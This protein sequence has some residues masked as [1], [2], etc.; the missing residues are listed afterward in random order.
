MSLYVRQVVKHYFIGCLASL[1]ATNNSQTQYGRLRI[2]AVF[3]AGNA[4]LLVSSGCDLRYDEG[5]LIVLP[6][7]IFVSLSFR[8]HHRLSPATTSAT[9]YF[10]V[11]RVK[12]LLHKNSSSC[13]LESRFVEHNVTAAVLAGFVSLST[14]S[15]PL[16]IEW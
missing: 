14:S 10:S 15:T 16:A 6:A 7:I 13:W 5:K 9:S 3:F 11:F 8:S 1:A 12:V 2:G 4:V